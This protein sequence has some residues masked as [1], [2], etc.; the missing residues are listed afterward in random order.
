MSRMTARRDKR[1]WVVTVEFTTS[2]VRGIVN[3]AEAAEYVDEAVAAWHGQKGPE[4]PLLSNV[5]DVKV[6]KVRGGPA[7]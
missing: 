6:V 1:R 7:R 5:A 4:D 3:E 2:D